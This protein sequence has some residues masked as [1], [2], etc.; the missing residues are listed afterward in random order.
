MGSHMPGKCVT[1]E[2]YRV[3]HRP[4]NNCHI[5]SIYIAKFDFQ[6]ITLKI[7]IWCMDVL[8][9]C[10]DLESWKSLRRGPFS[11]D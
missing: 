9:H 1:T 2:P 4:L 10:L 7:P 11:S 5:L 3:K 6:E 8:F